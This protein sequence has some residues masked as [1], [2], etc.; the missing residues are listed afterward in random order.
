MSQYATTTDFANTF[1][2]V[3][4]TGMSSALI[5]AH[6]VRASALADSYL[7][8]Q[9]SLPLSSWSEDLTQTIC[10]IAGYT[11]IRYR[12][13][14]PDGSDSVWKEDYAK[15]L[16][17]LDAVAKGAL[18]PVIVDSTPSLDEGGP[19]VSTGMAGRV[20]GSNGTYN[21]NASTRVDSS[22]YPQGPYTRGW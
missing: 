5:T 20:I 17:W 19:T 2:S 7:Q 3:A 18:T 13:F 15:A 12:G 14:K 21:D 16:E 9:Y 1:S 11:L 22:W 4:F 6:L 10:S 8:A